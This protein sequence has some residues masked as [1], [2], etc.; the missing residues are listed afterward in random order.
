MPR[1]L[2]GCLTALLAAPVLT[3]AWADTENPAIK[4]DSFHA[5]H[6][7]A[8]GTGHDEVTMPGLRGLDATAQESAEL[9]EMFNGFQGLN[10]T[11][12]LLPNGIRTYTW[13]ATPELAA[14]L[15]SHVTGMT[16]RV[17]EQ[18]DP[19]IF[20]QSP[21]LDILFE[22]ADSITTEIDTT[23]EGITVTQTSPDPEVVAALQTHAGEVTDM[24]NRGMLAVHEMMMNRAASGQ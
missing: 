5:E 4:H 9:Q 13:A 20:I 16:N 21:T 19:E 24:A 14:T 22:R 23:E 8:D 6:H 18:R 15:I 3:P 12:E 7:G 2:L 11:V 1:I 10:R 17:A